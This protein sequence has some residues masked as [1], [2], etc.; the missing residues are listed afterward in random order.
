MP[1]LVENITKHG[2]KIAGVMGINKAGDL[3]SVFMPKIIPGAFSENGTAIIG[4]STDLHSGHFF[5]FTDSS[6]LGL[7]AVIE[8]FPDIP[9]EIRPEEH[10]SSKFLKDTSWA[11]AKVPLGLA[12]FPCH[13]PHLLWPEAH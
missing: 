9:D 1:T 7:I 12:P 5:I 4:N 2:S 11:K 8:N 3:Q 6:D 13:C 10:L